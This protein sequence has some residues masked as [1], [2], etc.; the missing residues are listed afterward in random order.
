[1][2]ESSQTQAWKPVKRPLALHQTQQATTGKNTVSDK[3]RVVDRSPHNDRDEA[4]TNSSILVVDDNVD[5]TLSLKYLLES[6]GYTVNC[7]YEGRAALR[8][9]HIY[10]PDVAILDIGLPGMNGFD[11]AR[12]LR[13]DFPNKPLLL[14]AATGYGQDQDFRRTRQ[15]GFDYHLV[16]PL[17]IGRLMAIIAEYN[18]TC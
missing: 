14:I 5:M 3:A 6:L 11:V 17:D 13:A 4:V 9:A 2:N 16:K 7:A 1:M 8:A 10:K 15:A 18:E 12:R